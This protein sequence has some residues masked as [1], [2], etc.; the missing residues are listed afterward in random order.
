[1]RKAKLILLGSFISI[2]TLIGLGSTIEQNKIMEIAYSDLTKD[3]KKQVDCLAENIYHEAGYESE[4]GKQAVALVTLNRTQDERFPSNIC[5]VVKQK[6]Q[7]TCQFSWFCMPVKLN[8]ESVAYKQSMNV[9]LYVYA[10]YEKL[11]DVTDGALYYHADYV[12]P[13]WR[14]MEKTTTIGRHIFYKEK[15]KS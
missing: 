10:N 2:C 13:R 5:G 14:G 9:A 7:G 4:T 6:T 3:A 12:N 8:R 1:M 15:E 11:K